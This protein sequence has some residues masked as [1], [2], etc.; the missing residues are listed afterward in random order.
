MLHVAGSVC[1]NVARAQM[2]SQIINTL[3]IFRP[4]FLWVL[5]FISV[6][7]V[8]F[9]SV[10]SLKYRNLLRGC[11]PRLVLGQQSYVIG[12]LAVVHRSSNEIYDKFL[13]N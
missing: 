10:F 5:T 3:A 2:P 6:I 11:Y 13:R 1:R 8:P 7:E 12:M 4:A 9:F